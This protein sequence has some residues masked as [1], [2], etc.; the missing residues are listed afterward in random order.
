MHEFGQVGK[1]LVS[2]HFTMTK[3]CEK[4]ILLYQHLFALYRSKEQ[5]EG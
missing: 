1:D 3:I 5:Q 4:T 2:K